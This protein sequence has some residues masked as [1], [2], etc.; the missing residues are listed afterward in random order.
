MIRNVFIYKTKQC[1]AIIFK[2]TSNQFCKFEKLNHYVT[3]NCVY[4]YSFMYINIALYFVCHLFK[5]TY[6]KLIINTIFLNVSI[7]FIILYHYT[8]LNNCYYSIIILQ[9]VMSIIYF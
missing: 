9:N 3:Y 4:F 7:F 6:T 8:W 1:L 2:I 5:T